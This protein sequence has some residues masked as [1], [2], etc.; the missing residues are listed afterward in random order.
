MLLCIFTA[1]FVSVFATIETEPNNTPN[2]TGVTWCDNGSHTGA[3]NY[4]GDVD[5]WFFYGFPEDVVTVSTMGQTS[6]DTV[7]EIRN[8]FGVVVASN[9]DY[10]AT[11]QSYVEYTVPDD[12]TY[13]VLIR[14]YYNNPGTYG[15]TV[16]GEFISYNAVPNVPFNF[17]IPDGSTGV[18]PN[19]PNLTWT[20]G[21]G[22]CLG[23]W[24]MMFGASISGMQTL[25]M[26]PDMITT[27][28]D[29][30]AI[31]APFMG[32][33]TYYYQIF[34]TLQGVQYATPVYT[35]TVMPI[36]LPIPFIENFDSP[37]YQFGSVSEGYPWM[38]AELETGNPGS[39]YSP[40]NE[41]NTSYLI[42]SGTHDLTSASGAYMSF[43]HL[44]LLEPEDDHGYV[45]YSTDGGATWA[46][47]PAS[48]YMGAGVYDLP[49]GNNPLGP[50]YDAG[51]YANWA[52]YQNITN[53][54]GMWHTEV[55]DITPWAASS[56]FRVR[57]RSVFDDDAV[58]TGW[59]ID[60][61]S[62][63]YNSI[64]IPSL[65]NPANASTEVN[66]NLRLSWQATGAT[67]YDIGFGTNAAALT[68]YSS[69]QPYWDALNL[70]PYT[71][72]YWQVRSR[73]AYG[74]S[75]WSA[76]W[77]FS[78][79]Q[80]ATPWHQN[81][82][83][84]INRVVFGSIDNSSV[85]LGYTN[86]STLSTIAQ[87]GIDL[88]ISVYL[89]GGYGPEGVRVWVDV[90]RDAV[91]S[92]TSGANEYW[93]IPW[94][95]NCFQGTIH[96]PSNL[97]ASPTRMR[98]QAIHTTT[99]V[100]APSGVFQYGETEDY[101]LLTADN[102]ILSVSPDSASFPETLISFA[103]NPIRF[104]FSNT[105]GQILDIT[106]TGITGANADAFTLTEGNAYPIHLTNNTAS[107]DIR[108]IPQSLGLHTA[109]LLV[110]DNL[111]RTDHYYP[112]SG[113]GIGSRIDGALCFD[114][115]GEHVD[116]ASA[117]PLQNLTKVTLEAWFRYD[118]GAEIQF[119]TSKNYE[120]LE[121]HTVA[122]SGR[123][124]FIPTTGVYIDS[125]SGVLHTGQWQHLACVYDP[126]ASLAKIYIDGVDATWQNNG[127]NPL[128]TP[129][130]ST[131]SSF[132]FG[133]RRGLAYP[134]A[135]C[136]DEVRLWNIA[137]SNSEIAANMHLLQNPGA[138]GLTGYWRLDELS[139]D[140]I[141]DQIQ[142]LHGDLINM[143]AGDRIL[144]GVGLISGLS[145]PT[146]VSIARIGNSVRLTWIPVVGATRYK[147][148]SSPNP[149]G[150]FLLNSSGVFDGN[151]WTVPA[152]EECL[153]YKVVAEAF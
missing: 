59:I 96:L 137:R 44:A 130:Q 32:G 110:R 19:S 21:D 86:Y 100:L 7:I 91:F 99:D 58:G 87:C 150:S 28:Q 12:A 126:S 62:V 101:L 48:S 108:F 56:A 135:G 117:A 141:Y 128:T 95:T 15:L 115:S 16:S 90:N 70:A 119:L 132:I 18:D 146:G 84:S 77:N 23:S 50:C 54:S 53:I 80:Y 43:R 11:T 127:F 133:N 40:R 71:T 138:P 72:Y 49:G 47:F 36:S 38:T 98:V 65:P 68:Y 69:T 13:Y 52:G 66:T 123:L 45:E 67:G 113:T 35:F 148:L 88:P 109:N 114:G 103:S 106:L 93:D 124:R 39:I 107:V 142:S 26:F 63:Q 147:V 140:R 121:I 57:F 118:G 51:S 83:L 20:W 151:S 129:L 116:I 102:A 27:R 75:K 33:F 112:L 145:A 37:G 153:F 31:P 34:L 85:W 4:P 25:N 60:D 2:E 139:G 42:E 3:F 131:T 9:D 41:G 14:E 136:L 76:M 46:F 10:N 94:G 105:G 79:Q 78:T 122:S 120:E 143:E 104:T 81:S 149:E 92:N 30:I 6:M 74:T 1:I 55:F 144:S 73:N 125:Q 97:S 152:S 64:T 8:S 111:S 24:T 5:Y 82:T 61:F 17:N 89:A 134:L 22:C 29:G